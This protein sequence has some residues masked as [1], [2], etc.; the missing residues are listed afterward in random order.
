MDEF[1]MRDELRE[2]RKN[3]KTF[4]ELVE[5]L[6]DVE[7][8]YGDGYGE[9]P[10]AI[11]QA[12]LAVAWYLANRYGIT[13]FQAGCVMWDF[14][15]DWMYSNNRCGMKIV[16][17]DDMLYPQY[18]YKFGRTITTSTW[19]SIREEAKKRLEDSEYAH[20]DVI[21]HWKSIVA[22]RIPFGYVISDDL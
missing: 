12:C 7:K 1:A 10:R 19:N 11:A 21:A 15:S 8:N 2:K 14:I 18:S 9:A 6:K 13:G 22:G 3:I 17:Y 16:D 20:P 4:D 5:F